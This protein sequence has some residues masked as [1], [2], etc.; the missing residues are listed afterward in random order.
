MKYLFFL[1]AL[2]LGPWQQIHAEMFS[3]YAGNCV[4][5]GYDAAAIVV[6]ALNCGPNNASVPPV[7]SRLSLDNCLSFVDGSLVG[8]QG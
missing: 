4:N 7:E 8:G 1:S 6:V 5:V 3:G 2:L